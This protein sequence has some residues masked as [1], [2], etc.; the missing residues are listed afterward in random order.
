MLAYITLLQL[1]LYQA[2]A[3]KCFLK[4]ELE[5]Q[6]DGVSGV[7]YCEDQCEEF[8]IKKDFRF[9]LT[10]QKDISR[11][12]INIHDPQCGFLKC[13][14]LDGKPPKELIF[15]SHA[16][17]TVWVSVYS[18]TEMT[19]KFRTVGGRDIA[20]P[21]GWD[22]GITGVYAL[23]MNGDRVRDLLFSVGAGF[24]L[25][26][27]GLWAYDLK[28]QRELWHFYMGAFPRAVHLCDADQD[29]NSEIIVTTT[30]VDNGSQVNHFTDSCAYALCLNRNGNILWQR[31]VGG[32]FTDALSWVGD[33]DRDGQ[34][35][36]VVALCEG[37]AANPEPNRIL[38]LKARDGTTVK[39]IAS[40]EKYMGLAVQDLNRDE[41]LEIITGNTDGV[42][43]VF[44]SDL[45]LI[46]EKS[47]GTRVD[48]IGIADL[49]GE[50]SAEVI[51]RQPD[52]RIIILDEN[53]NKLCL[54][55][56][57]IGEKLSVDF[58]KDRGQRKLLLSAGDKPPYH[59]S[60]MSFSGPTFIDRVVGTRLNLWFLILAVIL[61]V[62]VPI[63]A[64]YTRELRMLSRRNEQAA[65]VLEWSWLAQRLAHEIKNP[66]STVNLTIQRIQEVS[67]KKFGEKAK[68]LDGYA[69]S[70]L[71]EVERIR[72]TTDKFM[73]ILSFD[74][75]TLVTANIN[76]LLEKVLQKYEP[77]LP[78]GIRLKKDLRPDLPF[79]PC[80]ENQIRTMLSNILENAIDALDGKG[81]VTV[82]TVTF[83][84]CASG[85][86]RARSA[87]GITKFVEVRI[88]DTGS[89]ISPENMKNIFKPF[90]TTKDGGS[91]IGLV[92]AKR[93]V[94]S[95]HG[96][97]NITSKVG[98]GTVATIHLPAGQVIKNGE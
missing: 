49:N 1:F 61:V 42:L 53:L 50:G 27:R 64:Y 31:P 59:Y 9:Y 55:T 83:G 14:D 86:T 39:Y 63:H 54:Y 29:G 7:A 40:G 46:Q 62:A 96:R 23:D 89:G 4:T 93:I 73:R 15:Q 18:G 57:A 81:T 35:E 72:D 94:D 30:A 38:V 70:I 91:G 92:I 77:I 52:S 10:D 3:G 34:P 79:L 21:E 37:T 65:K 47:F 95:H 48:L 66:L 74:N 41:K 58:L 76:S 98:V 36:V 45:H 51:L 67:K 68:V 26:P 71:E 11:F 13:L 16:N 19:A 28:N 80:D 60:V 88:E 75:P 12:Q 24:D 17:D 25:Q 69:D 5:F 97:I 33:L 87:P 20:K 82:S 32:A 84:S 56:S 44:D 90:Y 2:D 6:A 85:K 43:R 22:G 8:V 78:K